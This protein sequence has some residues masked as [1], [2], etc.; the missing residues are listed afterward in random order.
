MMTRDESISYIENEYLCTSDY[1]FEKYPSFMVMRCKDNEKWFAG[2][3]DVSAKQLGLDGE[4]RINLINLKCNPDLIPTLVHEN[5]IYRAYHMNKQ[6]WISIDYERYEDTEKLYM[7]ID[8]S[9]QLVCKK[10]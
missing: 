10:K 2:L 8:M 3:F 9:Y 4:Y 5:H 6:H 1:P 7:L